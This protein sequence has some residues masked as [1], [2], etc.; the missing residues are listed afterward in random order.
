[1]LEV[2]SAFEDAIYPKNEQ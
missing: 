1:M 2:D